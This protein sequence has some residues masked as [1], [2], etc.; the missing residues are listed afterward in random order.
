M[1]HSP[2]SGPLDGT[3]G[4]DLP[5]VGDLLVQGV[6]EVGGRQEGLDGE[7]HRSDLE[8]G[9]PLVLEDVQADSA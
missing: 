5:V 4:V 1:Q 3:F 2:L 7:E 6:V 8:G 9:A